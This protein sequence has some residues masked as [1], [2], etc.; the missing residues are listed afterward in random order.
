[1]AVTTSKPAYFMP[2]LCCPCLLVDEKCLRE[3]AG[4][5]LSPAVSIDT[6]RPAL[7]AAHDRS[8]AGLLSQA[9]VD[10][11]CGLEALAEAPTEPPELVAQY[12]AYTVQV[13]PRLQ[14]Y[15]VAATLYYHVKRNPSVR[16]TPSGVV[17]PLPNGVQAGETGNYAQAT[18]EARR[19]L[20]REYANDMGLYRQTFEEFIN[21]NEPLS[22]TP[23][24]QIFPCL[25][26]YSKCGTGPQYGS[27]YNWHLGATTD[28]A[29]RSRERD[30]RAPETGPSRT[31]PFETWYG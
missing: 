30:P 28:V 18:D 19:D 9:C 16:I 14:K 1:M 2:E 5:K 12:D 11:F 3:L 31:G 8:L 22:G 10:L 17:S 25:P 15:L 29:P 7:V 4:T 20:A 21:G 23:Y 24:R 6:L 27:G 13:R 26:A